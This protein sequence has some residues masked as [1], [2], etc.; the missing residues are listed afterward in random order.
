MLKI[1]EGN[2]YTGVLGKEALDTVEDGPKTFNV[3]SCI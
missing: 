3:R 2:F 1:V